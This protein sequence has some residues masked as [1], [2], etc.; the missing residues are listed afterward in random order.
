MG[1]VRDTQLRGQQAA[2]ALHRGA[3]RIF[4]NYRRDDVAS[5]AVLIHERLAAR[6][7]DEN[8]F[9]DV[10]SLKPGMRWLEQIKAQGETCAVFLS[11]IGDRWLSILKERERA[12]I[13]G[14]VDDYVR[15]EIEFALKRFSGVTVIPVLLEDA[16]PPMRDSLP[17]SLQPLAEIEVE[18]IRLERLAEDVDHLI[19]RLEAIVIE[20]AAAPPTQAAPPVLEPVEPPPLEPLEAPANRVAPVPDATHQDLVLQYMVDEGNLVPVLGSRINRGN[21]AGQP[22]DG[23]LSPPD[24]EDL[25]ADLAARFGLDGPQLDLAAVSQYVY[26]TRGRPDLYRTLKQILT[27]DYTPGAVHRFL[28][29]FP[30]RLEELG[31]ERR[32]QLIVSTNFDMALEQ[33]FEEE[34]EPYDLA[35][36]MVSGPDKGRFVHFPYERDPEAITLPNVYS[37]FPMGD[38]GELE[39]TVILKIHGAVDGHVGDY[40]WKENYVVTEDHYIDYLS[41]SPVESLV[42]I[43][44]LDKLK[45][46]HCLFLGYK[47]HD[48]HLRVFL[49]RIWRGEALGAKSW[50]VEQDPDLLEKELWAHSGVDLF[51]ADLAEYVDRLGGRLAA[52]RPASA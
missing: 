4:I 10:A 11:L 36:Y 48:W 23:T 18:Q 38:Y 13:T 7:G 30:R 42:P 47:M 28:A 45:D 22:S 19:R 46:S 37:K 25:A 6:F 49:Q 33:A 17:R 31:L 51:A 43:Q 21:Q 15:F 41:R 34:G 9:L 14:P 29:S 52:R 16:P 32:Y 8:V 27:A 3:L 12:T 44:I 20:R 24:A 50:A 1:D 40:R 26:M 2:D 39:R 5:E 35:V